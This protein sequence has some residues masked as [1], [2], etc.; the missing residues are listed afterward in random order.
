M[1]SSFRCVLG[2]VLLVAQQLPALKPPS[3]T[4]V[5]PCDIYA[6]GG[7][8]CVAA[9]SL[10]RALYGS[11]AG[12][13]Y[14]VRRLAD[15]AT[16]DIPVLAVGG[17]ADSTAQ[18]TFCGQSDCVVAQIFD[19]SPR[20]NNIAPPTA[21]GGRS[22]QCPSSGCLPVNATKEQHVVD[23]HAVFPAVFEGK[24]GYRNDTTSGIATGD[25]PESI[26]AVMVSEGPSITLLFS[27]RRRAPRIFVA[28]LCFCATS[29]QNVYSWTDFGVAS[30]G[31]Y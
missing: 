27:M 1:L 2:L 5:R 18:D 12:P 26:Y 24:M 9:F 6:S 29:H 25:E 19:Q 4:A 28:F 17:F 14:S 22:Y 15:G 3:L 7:T 8:P 16:K 21:S 30:H 20:A 23:G 31:N 13:L 10:V 11:Y